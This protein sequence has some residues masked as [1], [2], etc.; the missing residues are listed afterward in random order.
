MRFR[1]TPITMSARS[2][3]SDAG[4]VGM[5]RSEVCNSMATPAGSPRVGVHV[6]RRLDG[7]QERFVGQADAAAGPPS[8]VTTVTRQ[9]K[10]PSAHVHAGMSPDVA[11]SFKALSADKLE[12]VVCG[13]LVASIGYP[14][15]R[16]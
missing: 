7:D 5:Q 9:P 14:P 11:I 10:H 8:D 15:G 4:A 3:R 16:A 13:Q 12:C 1:S 2:A 6:R